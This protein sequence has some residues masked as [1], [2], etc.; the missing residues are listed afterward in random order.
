MAV[1]PGAVMNSCAASASFPMPLSGRPD[2]SQNA[3]P[4]TAAAA[5]HPVKKPN[6]GADRARERQPLPRRAEA[7]LRA[8]ALHITCWADGGSPGSTVWS[9]ARP[10]CTSW[11]RSSRACCPSG[12]SFR[13]ASTDRLSS[14]VVWPR[15]YLRSSSS[16]R[17]SILSVVPARNRNPTSDKRA[18]RS[19]L[20]FGPRASLSP[21]CEGLPAEVAR[22]HICE[23]RSAIDEFGNGGLAKS[24]TGDS[25]ARQRGLRASRERT[26]PA[27]S[28]EC[29]P[30]RLRPPQAILRGRCHRGYIYI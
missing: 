22:P 25:I 17:L 1:S 15:K 4:A 7:V 16:I 30:A 28:S 2:E 26:R 3:R 23:S 8:S 6:L 21:H 9:A 18:T 12:A 19:Q 13:Q 24:G 29:L 20:P 11:R 14:S 5:A 27:S 10:T